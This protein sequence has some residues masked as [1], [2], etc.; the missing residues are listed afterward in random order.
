[1]NRRFPSFDDVIICYIETRRNVAMLSRIEVAKV[2]MT[3]D[4]HLE[5]PMK[6]ENS[7]KTK[8]FITRKRNNLPCCN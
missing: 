8:F 4:E 1:M 2:K 5:L 6:I 3:A 7:I